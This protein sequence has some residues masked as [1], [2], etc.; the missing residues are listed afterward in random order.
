MDVPD[1][2]IRI[3]VKNATLALP[4]EFKQRPKIEFSG[5]IW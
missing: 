5:Q 1:H 3:S 4:P 2:L